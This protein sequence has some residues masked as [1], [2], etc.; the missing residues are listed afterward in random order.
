MGSKVLID[1]DC[2]VEEI[3]DLTKGRGCA[4]ALNSIGGRSSLRLAKCL[5]D[6]AVHV[7]FGAMDGALIRFPTRALIF[8]DIRFVGFWLDRWKKVEIKRK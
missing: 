6:G 8:K 5:S 7:T 1:Q 4:L 2:S 3:I